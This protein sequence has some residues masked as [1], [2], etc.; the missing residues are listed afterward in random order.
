MKTT[1]ADFEAAKK[2][3]VSVSFGKSTT[4]EV[5]HSDEEDGSFTTA[6]VHGGKGSPR[7]T[8]RIIEEKDISDGRTEEQKIKEQLEKEEREQLEEIQANKEY[9]RKLAEKG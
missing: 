7:P 2:K 9:M 1:T 3:E 5:L 8:K 4:Y 6:D